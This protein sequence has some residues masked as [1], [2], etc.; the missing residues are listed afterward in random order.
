MTLNITA[1]SIRGSYAT[2]SIKDNQHYETQHTSVEY[3]YAECRD[4]LNVMLSYVVP[5]VIMLSVD[6]LN[7]VAPFLQ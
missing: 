1:F 5:S 7:V 2:L 3:T 6:M 4:Y